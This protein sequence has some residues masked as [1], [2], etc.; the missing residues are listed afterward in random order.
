MVVT[1]TQLASMVPSLSVAV[2]LV[3]PALPPALVV[4]TPVTVGSSGFYADDFRPVPLAIGTALSG[5]H[6]ALQE[7]VGTL[8]A[9]Y[10]VD[11]IVG[12]LPTNQEGII[13]SGRGSAKHCSLL[14]DVG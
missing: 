9:H 12:A 11:V 7:A 8:V 5:G 4:V 14:A 10:G 1:L 2:L 3:L 6:M 13:H